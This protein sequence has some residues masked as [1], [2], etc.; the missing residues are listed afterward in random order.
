MGIARHQGPRSP[1]SGWAARRFAE[2]WDKGLDDLLARRH[3]RG[4]RRRPASPRTTSTP[5]GSAPPSRG[6]S[7][8]VAGQAAAAR[9]QAGHPG[10]E[11]VRHRL[12]GAAPGRLRRGLRRLRPGH[13]GRR[14]EG[15][16]LRL[17]GPQRLPDP[18]RRHQPHA[19]RRRHVLDGRARLRRAVRRRP[20]TSC[21]GSLAR[22]ASKNHY[23]GARNPRAQF[24]REMRVDADLRHARRWP[25]TCR[26]FDCAGVADGAAAAIV[27]PGRGRPPLHRQAALREGAVVRGRQRHRASSTPTTTTRR[28]PRSPPAPTDAYAQAGVTDPRRQL[29][30]A[31]VHD[32]FTPT[33]LVLMEDL[34][35]CRAGQGLEGRARPAPST[36]TASCR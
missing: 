9:G 23:N 26:V 8:M 28:S 2:H 34:G 32:C 12:R 19:H 22:I 31:E 15:E 5:T 13:G 25:A 30:M 16:G 36:S 29:A 20:R 18:D 21:G 35:F 7:G 1:S 24:R 11:H 14:R 3:R 10:R 27:V 6:M 4:V 33:E 17:P